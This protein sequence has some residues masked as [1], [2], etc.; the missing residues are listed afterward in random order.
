MISSSLDIGPRPHQRVEED[1][2]QQVI[3]RIDDENLEE[4]VGQFLAIRL[5]QKIHYLAGGPEGRRRDQRRLHQTAGGILRIVERTAQDDPFLRGQ[6]LENLGLLFRLQRL[7]DGDGV[8]AFQLAHALDER[9]DRQFF[10]NVFTGGFTHLHERGKVEI[11]AHEF[12]EARARLVTQLF[13]QRAD[14]GLVQIA[15][16]FMNP[17]RVAQRNGGLD[18][19][20]EIG[21]DPAAAFA[22]T[23]GCCRR[24]FRVEWH[25]DSRYKAQAL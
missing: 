1:R 17:L 10:E 12:D 19:E 24:F 5:A 16:E 11:R 15:D 6:R 8:V 20:N 9:L 13:D 21:V 3:A 23:F 25:A 22:E 18:L 14:V 7:E 2:A 4:T